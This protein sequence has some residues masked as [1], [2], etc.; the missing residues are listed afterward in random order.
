[1]GCYHLDVCGV[2]NTYGHI[3]FPLCGSLSPP[4]Y[5]SILISSLLSPPPHH[6]IPPHFL[7][8]WGFARQKVTEHT[9]AHTLTHCLTL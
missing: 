6:S 1:M 8:R 7:V 3:L 2:F 9:L 4:L 5:I